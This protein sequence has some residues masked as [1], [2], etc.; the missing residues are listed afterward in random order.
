MVCWLFA[1]AVINTMRGNLSLDYYNLRI[2][3]GNCRKF[4]VTRVTYNYLLSY[5]V[6]CC[7]VVIKPK[8]INRRESLAVFFF[9]G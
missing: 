4:H 8:S 1:T 9:K 3:N 2:D 7:S 6:R 5:I